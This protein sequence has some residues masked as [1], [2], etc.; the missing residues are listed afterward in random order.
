ME[1]VG[2]G[3][4]FGMMKR[5]RGT[6]KAMLQR[7]L[8]LLA[9]VMGC[10]LVS[11]VGWAADMVLARGPVATVKAGP[12]GVSWEPHVQYDRLVLTVKRPGGKVFRKEFVPG[13]K[14]VFGGELTDGQYTY[15]LRVIPILTPE[16]RE[17]LK[18]A[19]A[20]GDMSIVDQLRA[21]GALPGGPQVQSGYFRVYGGAVILPDRAEKE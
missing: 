20:T 8:I 16:V 3:R 21:K 6:T 2:F 11:S 4:P 19:R 17:A 18:R 15:E 7:N 5:F 9:A 10:A 12:S 14:L 1:M 13:S